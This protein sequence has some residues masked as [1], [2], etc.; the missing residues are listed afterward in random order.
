MKILEN[1]AYLA[2]TLIAVT[3]VFVGALTITNELLERSI[4]ALKSIGEAKVFATEEK[5]TVYLAD[6]CRVNDGKNQCIGW[7]RNDGIVYVQRGMSEQQTVNTCNHEILHNIFK[8]KGGDES[9]KFA[10]DFEAKVRFK[11]CEALRD[12]FKK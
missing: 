4:P 2:L 10:S 11:E 12:I 3:V 7:T 1:I 5:Y 8:N 6:E 9:E